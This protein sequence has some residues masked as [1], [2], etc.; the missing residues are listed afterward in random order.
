MIRGDF[1]EG[2]NHA[3][4]VE[5]WT[6]LT[7]LGPEKVLGRLS[8]E[9]EGGPGP[10][11]SPGLTLGCRKVRGAPGTTY[12]TRKCSDPATGSD[13]PSAWFVITLAVF[14]LC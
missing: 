4:R 11:S 14:C 8:S 5:K 12:V 13:V 2:V 9:S 7:A 3:L 6:G 10:G 1:L